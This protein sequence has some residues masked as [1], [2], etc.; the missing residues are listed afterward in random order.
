MLE[1]ILMNEMFLYYL[2]EVGFVGLDFFSFH[3]T[4][5]LGLV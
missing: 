4:V 2:R 5:S 3:C 1:I